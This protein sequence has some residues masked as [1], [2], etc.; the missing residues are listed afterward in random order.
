MGDHQEKPT[1]SE[2]TTATSNSGADLEKANLAQEDIHSVEGSDQNVTSRGDGAYIDA[3]AEKRLVRKI[4]WN[5]VPILFCMYLMSQLDRSNVGNAKIAGMSKDLHFDAKGNDYAWLLTIFYI[6]YI[7]FEWFAFMWK[8]VPPHIWATITICAWGL[9]ATLQAATTNWKG[10][11]ALRFLLGACEAGF[12]PG[13]P[14]LLSFF[15]MRQELGLRVGLFLSAGALATC[16]AGALAYGI[17]S[18]HAAIANW[19]LLF[20]VE[21][22]PCFLLAVFVFFF[23][24]D[25]PAKAKFLNED[26]K[27]VA[28]ARSVR[29]VGGTESDTASTRVGSIVWKDILVALID[30]KNYIT[31]IMYFS[32]NVSFASLPVFLPTILTEMGYTAIDAQGLSA[33]PY[34]IA[35][36]LVIASTF[37]ADR[38][39]Q[40]GF[41]ILSLSLLGAVGYIILATTSTSGVRY[42]GVYFAA[43]GIYP[44]IINILPWVL[45]NQGSDTKRGAGIVILN[46]VGQCG[47]LLGTRIYPTTDAPYYRMGMWVCAA[48][49]L[50]NGFLAFALR[51][52]LARENKKLDAQHGVVEKAA[53]GKPAIIG[54]END[55]VNFRYVL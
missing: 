38:T 20:L 40:R 15:Y 17:T 55:G 30:P 43:A 4:D 29:Q 46:L 26:D 34:F 24:P 45:N 22:L 37:V 42:F 16:F 12:G 25:S 32:C 1:T 41:V 49:M 19:K 52:Y 48:F 7:V 6:G 27:A 10:M 11:M 36:L 13:V 51:T 2:T 44:A 14:Y 28:R 23:L 54:V 9:I 47:P 18:G 35:F 3:A 33:P 50:L 5:L 31:A 21:G 39:G 8:V 53:D